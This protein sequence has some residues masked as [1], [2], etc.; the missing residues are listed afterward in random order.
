MPKREKL[1]PNQLDQ[2]S[3]RVFKSLSSK[4]VFFIKTILTAKKSSLIAKL[5]CFGGEIFLMGKGGD[6]GI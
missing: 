3:L 1:R 4:L 5:F 2:P 6:F